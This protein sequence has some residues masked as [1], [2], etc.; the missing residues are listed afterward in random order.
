MNKVI[1]QTKRAEVAHYLAIGLALSSIVISLLLWIITDVSFWVILGIETGFIIF[2]I[3]AFELKYGNEYTDIDEAEQNREALINHVGEAVLAHQEVLIRK[4]RTLVRTGDYGEIIAHDW[5][6]EINKFL[7]ITVPSDAYD[8]TELEEEKVK[9]LLVELVDNLIV[10]AIN[11]LPVDVDLVDVNQLSGVEYEVHCS[12]ILE[13]AGWKVSRT[14]TTGDQGIDLLAKKNARCVAVQCKRFSHPVGNK[15]VQEAYTGMSF[16][17][18]N[19]AIVVSNAP[20]TKSAIQLAGKLSV[21]L[22]HDT[23]LSSL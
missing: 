2:C 3:T 8:G 15:A 16:Y 12:D 19:E 11:E 23:E 6:R 18:A 14:P 5:I 21:A 17:E 22:I 1:Y 13:A 20:F 10:A 7:E 4:R 9:E